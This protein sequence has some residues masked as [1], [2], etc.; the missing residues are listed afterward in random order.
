MGP[1]YLDE[2]HVGDV[3]YTA[4]RTITEADVVMFAG[5]TGDYT[6]IHTSQTMAESTQFGQRI[7]HGILVLAYAHG[8]FMTTKLTTPTGIALAGIE[9]W[10]FK[11]PVFFGDTIQVKVSISD[12]IPSR[13]KIDRGIVKFFFEVLKQDGSVVQQGTKVIM[14]KRS[15]EGIKQMEA[16]AVT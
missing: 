3:F 1:K 4:S 14:M 2:L 12:I 16:A 7:A 8:L 9:D 13:S 5:L 15:P 10:K 6:E 11:A